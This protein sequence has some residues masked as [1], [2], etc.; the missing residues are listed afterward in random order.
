MLFSL[1]IQEPPLQPPPQLF[2]PSFVSVVW[3]SIFVSPFRTPTIEGLLYEIVIKDNTALES[4]S[5][6]SV[7]GEEIEMDYGSC[8]TFILIY[9]HAHG[10]TNWI[11]SNNPR[12]I[13]GGATLGG[14]RSRTN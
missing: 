12:S 6:R 14:W 11:Q 5:E 8:N 10:L 2:I 4:P 3:P 13:G 9:I 7:V 1:S